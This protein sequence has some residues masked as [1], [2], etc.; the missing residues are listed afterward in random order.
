MMRVLLQ[1][2]ALYLGGAPVC[3][4]TVGA[5][6]LLTRG[7]GAEAAAL[8]NS[9][10]SMVRDPRRCTG[11][12]PG[13][14]NAGGAVMGEHLFLYD[15]ARYNFVGLSVPSH[16]GAFGMGAIQ[17]DRGTSSPGMHRRSGN[18]SLNTPDEPSPGLRPPY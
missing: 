15:G 9:I 2:L 5:T 6:H 10:V 17:L 11:T 1:L 18:Q 12:L 7:P 13:L 4:E 14:A 3:A 16:L 8:G